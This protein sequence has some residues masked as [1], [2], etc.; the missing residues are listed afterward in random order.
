MMRTIGHCLSIALGL[1][2]AATTSNIAAEDLLRSAA[3][4][5][6]T[7]ARAANS[8]PLP[9]D[10]LQSTRQ[11]L[12]ASL[13]QL[14]R[15]LAQGGSKKELGWRKWLNLPALETALAA[16]QPRPANLRPFLERFDENQPGLESPAFV[17]VR[18]A[19]RRYL[20]ASEYSESDLPDELYN[21]RL[22]EL[23]DCLQRLDQ[24]PT[25]ED[26][27]KAGQLLSWFEALGSDGADLAADIRPRYCRTNGL[28][29]G[30]ARLINYLLERGVAEHRSIADIV[31]GAYTRGTVF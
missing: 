16:N 15:F 21:E 13:D 8:A 10:A 23:S 2:A 1:I 18:Q 30:S 22:G 5:D 7:L 27:A 29:C 26:A 3:R 11:H 31:L 19:L 24:V 14:R 20:T 25:A 4:M 17:N 9:G 28:M 12:D 6:A